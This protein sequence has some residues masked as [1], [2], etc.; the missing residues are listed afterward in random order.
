MDLNREIY[1]FCDE[2]VLLTSENEEGE[3]VWSPV[4]VT[5]PAKYLFFLRTKNAQ[6]ERKEVVYIYED[7]T[8]VGCYDNLGK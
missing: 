7:E 8:E 4:H 2:A 3:T 1:G 5:G 6:G